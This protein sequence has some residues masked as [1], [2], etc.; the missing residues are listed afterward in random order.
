MDE[1]VFIACV[2]VVFRVLRLQYRTREYDIKEITDKEKTKNI[3]T[4]NIEK[5]KHRNQLSEQLNIETNK[6]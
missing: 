2:K 6:T 1:M 4:L 3:E 5:K